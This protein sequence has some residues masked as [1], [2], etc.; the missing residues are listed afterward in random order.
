MGLLREFLTFEIKRLLRKYGHRMPRDF[1]VGM[2]WTLIGPR[3]GNFEFEGKPSFRVSTTSVWFAQRLM[4][5]SLAIDGRAYNPHEVILAAGNERR[6]INN[7]HRLP[8]IPGRVYSF[9]VPGLTLPDGIHFIDLRLKT[10]LQNLDY[11][12]LPI[13]LENGQGGIPSALGDIKPLSAGDSFT[14][15]YVPHIH[16]DV[17]WIFDRERFI[18]V[19]MRNLL[20]A[21]SILERDPEHTFVVDQVPQLEPFFKQFPD[22]KAKFRRWAEEGRIEATN[23]LYAEP[24]VNLAGGESLVRAS[25]MWQKYAVEHFGGLSRVG[26][27]IDCFGQ[28]IQIPQILVK[29]GTPFFA[30]NR[31]VWDNDHPADFWWEGPDGSRVLTHWMKGMYNIGY[32]I[33]EEPD[34]AEARFQRTL[35]MIAPNRSSNHVLYPAGVDHGRPLEFATERIADWNKSHPGTP[36]KKSTPLKYFESLDKSKLRV[37]KG[38]FQRDLWGVYSTR[39]KGKIQNRRCEIKTLHAETWATAAAIYGDDYPDRKLEEQWKEILADQFHDCICGCSSDNVAEGIAQRLSAAEAVLDAVR[40]KAKRSIL[41]R[42]SHRNAPEGAISLTVFN[43]LS[44]RRNDWIEAKVYLKPGVRDVRLVDETG[45]T[46]TT[47]D[48]DRHYYLNGDILELR[49]GWLAELPPLGWQTFY[50]KPCAA[51]C[52]SG[53]A[54]L[55][56]KASLEGLISDRMTALTDPRTGL[57]KSIQDKSSG[58]AFNLKKGN[59]LHLQRDLGTLYNPIV[60][61]GGWRSGRADV[62]VVENGPLRSTIEARGRISKNDYT[63]RISLIAGL[64]RVD[65]ET[66]VDLSTPYRRLRAEFAPD[67]KGAWRHGAPYGVIERPRHELPARDW[68]DLSDD[69]HG[70]TLIQFGTPGMS[71]ERGRMTIS[72]WRSTDLIHFIPAGPGALSL[73]KHVFRYSIHPHGPFAE[74]RPMRRAREHHEPP[75]AVSPLGVPPLASQAVAQ[76]AK[77]ARDNSGQAVAQG[78]PSSHSLMDIDSDQLTVEAFYR[79][80]ANIIVRILESCGAH[81]QATVSLGF[82][83]KAAELTDLIGNIERKLEVKD[84]QA[85]I[86]YGPYQIITLRLRLQGR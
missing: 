45:K 36:I 26:W 72:L 57:I 74:A 51:S 48:I 80:G 46:V 73:G 7:I 16:Y 79:E 56:C 14:A 52:E 55:R 10:D 44:W 24:D 33:M 65:F 9:I 43:P 37:I 40:E 54:L 1:S 69:R 3:T 75:E 39:I 60:L 64:A 2:E 85:R 84:G 4:E 11:A 22:M 81:G 6:T 21:A 63:Q 78:L 38:E 59:Q 19:S 53:G 70:L 30:F 50:L 41:A 34:L 31:V 49:L 62:R 15:H 42:I 77:Q 58:Y 5:A 27:F 82:D 8:F 67:F 20:D 61:P 29:S 23:G 28:S 32:P 66:E 18:E 25:I 12:G 86:P 76:P 17:E 47:Q 68:A 83:V 13:L 71:L 35:G